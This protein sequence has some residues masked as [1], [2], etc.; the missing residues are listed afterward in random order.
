LK[1]INLRKGTKTWSAVGAL[2]AMVLVS[3]LGQA[4]GTNYYAWGPMT[5]AQSGTTVTTTIDAGTFT[6]HSTCG[7]GGPQWNTGDTFTY[8]SNWTADNTAGSIPLDSA[9]HLELYEWVN[10][11]PG[12]LLQDWNGGVTYDNA[13]AYD[14]PPHTWQAIV[15]ATY[16]GW[17]GNPA[18]ELSFHVYRHA[19]SPNPGVANSE[20]Y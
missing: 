14:S 1:K 13:A 5:V 6:A 12:N 3:G 20:W 9:F 17:N 11:A 7:A 19:G 8:T 2:V 15:T 16:T 18:C 10:G 4:A